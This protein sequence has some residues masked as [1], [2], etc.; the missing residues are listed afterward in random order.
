MGLLF[1][2][3]SIGLYFLFDFIITL[4]L[5]GWVCFGLGCFVL[6]LT[7]IECYNR[8]LFVVYWF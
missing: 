3:I 2:V 8:R 1:A 5:S 7:A 6:S 4:A